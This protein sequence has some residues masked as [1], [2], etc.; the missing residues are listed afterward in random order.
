MKEDTR[1]HLLKLLD[2]NP[3]LTQRDLAEEL[4]ISLGKVNYCMRALLDQGLV[5]AKRFRDN[6]D[7]RSYVYLLTPK[8]IEHRARLTVRY[9]KR[10]VAEYEAL[11]SEIEELRREAAQLAPNTMEELRREAPELAP[12]TEDL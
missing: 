5:K 4:G 7:K 10:K 12:S 8:G 2:A 9:L 11:Q 6:P 3:N 1:L